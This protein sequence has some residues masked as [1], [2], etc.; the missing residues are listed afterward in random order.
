MSNLRNA[1]SQ[2]ANQ[3]ATGVLE[4][5]RGASLE[6]ILLETKGG[7][8]AARRGPAPRVAHVKAHVTKEAGPIV[9]KAAPAPAA[10]PRKRGRLERRSAGDIAQVVARIVALLGQHS[11]G[12]RA[13]QIRAKLGLESKELP[14]PI[15]Q[16]LEERKISKAGEKRATTYFA[17]SAKATAKAA[18]AKAATKSASKKKAAPAKKPAAKVVAKAAAPKVAAKVAPKAAAKA[19]P[20]AAPKAAPAKKAAPKA[21][22]PVA[23]AAA[24][25][26][27]KP[28]AKAAAKPAKAP[29]KAAKPVAKAKAVAKPA[30]AKAKPVAKAVAKPAAAKPAAKPVAKA[31]P[32]KAAP[33]APKAKPAPKADVK[34]E[35]L[36]VSSASAPIEEA[37][38]I[39]TNG[40]PVEV[41]S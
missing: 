41:P 36:V 39:A 6:D 35:P 12:L 37:V 15:T 26:A 8:G 33:K 10:K 30:A 4:A 31:A 21:A 38:T 17:G 34:A 27:A 23:K 32:K 7:G 40:V 29:A 3:F 20:K 11:K 9:A 5:I 25:P 22:K 28:V 1:I 24:K 18:P 13:E 19:G 2:L 14:R 16:A